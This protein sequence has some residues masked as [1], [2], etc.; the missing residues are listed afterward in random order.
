MRTLKRGC[1]NL[2]MVNLDIKMITAKEVSDGLAEIIISYAQKHK[3]TISNIGESVDKVEAYMR[4]NAFL[5]EG[6]S[7]KPN[8]L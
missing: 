5:M 2:I 3:M 8:P 7:E 4:D 6:D 1:E